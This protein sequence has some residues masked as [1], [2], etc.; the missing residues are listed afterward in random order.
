MGKETW[1][2]KLGTDEVPGPDTFNTRTEPGVDSPKFTIR[3]RYPDRSPA[4]TAPYRALPTTLGDAPKFTMRP[5]CEPRLS[6][7]TPGPSYI[8]P[9]FGSDLRKTGNST[10]GPR[11]GSVE[12]KRAR[13][14][15]S[16]SQNPFG[17]AEFDARAVPGSPRAPAYTIA[18]HC[19]ESWIRKNANPGA[20]TYQPNF[21][22]GK[23]GAPRYSIGQVCNTSYDQ[24][25]PGPGRYDVPAPFGSG[26]KM[27]VGEIRRRDLRNDVPGPGTY[28][29]DMPLGSD[30]RKATI[31]QRRESR[32]PRGTEYKYKVAREFDYPTGGKTIGVKT[33]SRAREQTPGPADYYPPSPRSARTHGMGD[34]NGKR[35]DLPSWIT[36]LPNPG[37]GAYNVE[38]PREG[39][40]FTLHE[41]HGGMESTSASPGPKYLP[42]DSLTHVR[43]PRFTMRPKVYPPE[44]ECATKNAGYYL[45]PPKE[46]TPITIHRKD[47][48]DLIPE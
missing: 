12:P 25:F 40:S 27:S 22:C 32:T 35:E 30:A 41:G 26:K 37:P 33:S 3:P 24:G 44:G 7:T 5:K 13:L 23:R 15:Q 31:G 20:G 17:P 29:P 34:R 16:Y 8:P 1:A 48:T 9:P 43:S 46:V 10:F 6:E 42:D 36:I 11:G 18:P 45:L 28:D 47:Y 21:H 4:Q 19:G 38:S 2:H 39:P 14:Y